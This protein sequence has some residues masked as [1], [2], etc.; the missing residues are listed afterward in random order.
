MTNDYGSIHA[1]ILSSFHV[2]NVTFRAYGSP[3]PKCSTL[4]LLEI[5]LLNSK[6]II[7]KKNILFVM[8]VNNNDRTCSFIDEF[9]NGIKII[10]KYFVGDFINND[11]L[12][13]IDKIIKKKIFFTGFC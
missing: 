12:L 10:K 13:F 8:F 5:K 4:S 3:P 7:G 9:V 1:S 6:G 2:S 11:M